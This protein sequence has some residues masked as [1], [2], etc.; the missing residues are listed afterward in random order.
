MIIVSCRVSCMF[1][2]IVDC[3]SKCK[4][5]VVSLLIV[6]GAGCIVVDCC[7]GQVVSLLI[8]VRGRLYCC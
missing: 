1:C 5:Q 6:V 7:K 3:L 8:I 2:I 4:G